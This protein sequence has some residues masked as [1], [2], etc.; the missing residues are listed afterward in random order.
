M[1]RHRDQIDVLLAHIIHNPPRHAALQHH[2]FGSTSR[3][4]PDPAGEE[5]GATSN[6]A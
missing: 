6:E 1:G 3:R 4:Q 2:R 5:K